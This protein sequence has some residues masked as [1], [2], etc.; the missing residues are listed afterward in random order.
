MCQP[1]SFTFDAVFNLFTSFGYFDT[2]Q[3]NFNAI[4]AM[5]ANMK[6]GA[7]GVIDFMNCQ[8]EIKHLKPYHEVEV[9]QILFK[10]EKWSDDDYIYKKINFE[11]EDGKHTYVERVKILNLNH[12]QQFFAEAGLQ[13]KAIFGNYDLDDFDEDNAQRLILLFQR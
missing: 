6:S 13:Q 4:N 7:C 1:M 9:D 5:K 3:E 12:F 10:I 8:R 11:D 2:D